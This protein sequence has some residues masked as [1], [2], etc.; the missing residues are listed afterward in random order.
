MIATI[1]PPSGTH[2]P[3]DTLPAAV[4]SSSTDP[5]VAPDAAQLA[6][7]RTTL[8]HMLSRA[9]AESC[10]REAVTGT[11]ADRRAHPE[12]ADWGRDEAARRHAQSAYERGLDGAMANLQQAAR[13][14]Q[15]LAR[16]DA[17]EGK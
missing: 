3:A 6:D 9:I 11:G 17:A 1:T 2:V 14:A 15:E 7:M 12:R 16:L 13:A 10:R 4:P 8:A 5:A